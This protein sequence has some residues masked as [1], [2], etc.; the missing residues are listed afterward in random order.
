MERCASGALL[1]LLV[2][3]AAVHTA[4]A[5]CNNIPSIDRVTLGKPPPSTDPASFGFKGALGRIDRVH[6]LPAAGKAGSS[7]DAP[8]LTVVADGICVGPDGRPVEAG[9]PKLAA[10]ED[11]VALVYFRSRDKTRSMVRAYGTADSCSALAAAVNAD[12]GKSVVSVM[13]TCSAD[14]LKAVKLAAGGSGLRIPVPDATELGSGGASSAVRIVV[15]AKGKAAD[16]VIRAADQSCSQMCAQSA[17]GSLEICIDEI[18]ALTGKRYESDPIPCH[19]EIPSSLT[20]AND[21]AKSCENEDA[22]PPQ[23]SQSHPARSLK[24]WQ[25]TCGGVHVPFDWKAIRTLSN[26]T[27]IKREVRGRTG[28]GR[29][30]SDDDPAVWIPGREFLG[31]TPIADPQGTSAGVDWRKPLVDVWSETPEEFGLQGVVDQNDSIVHI[32]PRLRTKVVCSAAA[33]PNACMGVDDDPMGKYLFCACSDFGPGPC[34]CN[35]VGTARYFVCGSGDRR[36]MPC[37][38]D[39]HCTGGGRCD[40]QPHCQDAGDVWTRDKPDDSGTECTVDDDC[41]TQGQKTQCGYR[42]FNLHDAIDNDDLIVLD[43]KLVGGGPHK[44]RGVCKN[45]GTTPCGNGMGPGPCAHGECRGYQLRAGKA[46]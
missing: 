30:K 9:T 16:L 23:C 44:R 24:L 2:S 33:K 11:L 20:A 29:R 32:F 18:Y 31:S 37:T 26:G 22:T 19:V 36:G 42:L 41:K 39:R 25:D 13:R 8:A 27:K 1:C 7:A 10:V 45:D 43:P 21:F 40:G 14:G 34:S 17:K 28:V 35:E 6:A 38:R 12:Q 3:A 15:A 4:G 46:Q 5:A